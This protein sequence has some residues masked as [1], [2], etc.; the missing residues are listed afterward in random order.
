VCEVAVAPLVLLVDVG[1]EGGLE[2]VEEE[3]IERFHL[4][5]K[6]IQL[7]SESAIIEELLDQTAFLGIYD[8]KPEPY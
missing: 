5:L 3:L 7:L 4:L 6:L 1:A 2:A 8:E